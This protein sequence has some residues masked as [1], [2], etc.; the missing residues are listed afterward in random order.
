MPGGLHNQRLPG[1][2]KVILFDIDGTLVLT[3]GAG[4]RAMSQ[5][6]EDLFSIPNAF[7]NIP[8]FGR[9]DASIVSDAAT[10]FGIAPDSAGLASFR[11]V[12]VARLRN[13]VEQPGPSKGVMPG[14]RALLA[15]LARRD[16]VYLA[17]LTGNYED[18]ARVKLE[19]FD[20]WHYFPCG[21]FGDNAPDRN[22]L[23]PRALARIQA[24]GGPAVPASET[25]VVGDTPLDVACATTSGAR[26]IAVAT[27]G[28]SSD[29]LRAAGADVVLQDLGDTREVLRALR[30]QTSD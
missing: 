3:G 14:V 8:M 4:A 28:Y 7:T 29:A 10:A 15:A 18:G 26:S 22:G 23:L 13:E 24:C 5:A 6:F 12:Y 17:L 30:L 19:Y 16:D 25:I 20:L 21:A 27:G 11:D 1:V 9:T 2:T